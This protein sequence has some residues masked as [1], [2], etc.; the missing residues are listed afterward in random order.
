MKFLIII[1]ISITLINCSFD[2]RTGIWKNE[3]PIQKRDQFE[4]FEK[5]SITEK[6]FYKTINPPED[7]I[8][9]IKIKINSDWNDVFYSKNNNLEN[10]KYNE[11]YRLISKSK[12]LS[13][14]HI[15]ER[16]LYNG[17]N[18]YFTDDKGN[19]IIFS[20]NENKVI[21]KFN[22][23]KKRYKKFSKKLNIIIENNVVYVSD[24]I[25]YLYAYDVEKEKIIWAKNLKVPFRSNFKIFKNKLIAANQ[26]NELFFFDKINGNTINSIP[27]EE[28]VIKNKFENNLSMDEN[29]LFFLNTY[30]SLYSINNNSM[31]INWFLNL[32][33]TTDLNP[34]NLFLSNQIVNNNEKIIISS[35]NYLYILDVKNGS[36]IFKKNISTQIKPIIIEEDKLLFISKTNL[37]IL[38]NL[39]NGEFIYSIDINQKIAD[40]LNLRK[41]NAHLKDI[42]ILN[43]NLFIF[44]NNSFIIKFNLN[45]NIEKV[46]KLPSK[47]NT[48]PILV[49]NRILYIDFKNKISYID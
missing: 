45:G 9:K 47:I 27:T 13:K 24:N 28:T 49:N 35:N 19:L 30:G 41:K 44:L 20:V 43:N 38:M 17:N 34:S 1:I 29:N 4:K 21:K 18:A 12:K 16:I 11:N 37:L 2:N 10:F 3:N 25:G 26:N 5:L 23:Y 32:N 48:Y 36:L 8:F 42:M 40:Y 6:T 7:L 39:D 22:F 31:K 14:Y 33:Q 15:N 46:K